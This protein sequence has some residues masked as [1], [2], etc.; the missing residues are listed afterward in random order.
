MRSPCCEQFAPLRITHG[1]RV[2]INGAI[3]PR[4]DGYSAA[5]TMDG[6]TAEAYHFP[7]VQ[8]YV[9]AGADIAQTM[10]HTQARL[11]GLPAQPLAPG[12]LALFR[13]D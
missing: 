7:Q 3:G 8:A 4:S 12:F 11:S 10:K 5:E 2:T 13:R 1:V 9:V 6:T